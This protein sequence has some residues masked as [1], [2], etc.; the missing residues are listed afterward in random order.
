MRLWTWAPDYSLRRLAIEIKLKPWR[1]GRSLAAARLGSL[2]Y[3]AAC[4]A[5]SFSFRA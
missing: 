3:E 4:I 1:R 2:V 5:V